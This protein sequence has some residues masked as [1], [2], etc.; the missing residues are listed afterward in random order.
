MIRLSFCLLFAAMLTPCMAQ[1]NDDFSDGDFTNNPAWSGDLTLFQVNAQLE[2][3]SAGNPATE[4]IYL[5]TPSTRVSDTEWRF[6]VR[7]LNNP[8]SSNNL[9]VYLVSDQADL[10]GPLNGYFIAA[11]GESGLDDSYDLYRQDGSSETLLIDGI[12]GLANPTDA[13]LQVLRDGTGN[14]SLAVDQGSTG[15][16]LSQGNANDATY[17]SST[18]MGVVVAHTSTRASDYFVDDVY[19]GD[20]VIDLDPPQL[21][22]AEAL[23]DSEVAVQFDEPLDQASATDITHYNLDQGV[24]QPA[25]AQLDGT[26]PTR[27]L[28]TLS[29]LL[30][31]QT[32]YELTV[33]DVADLSGNTIAPAQSVSFLYLVPDQPGLRDVIFNEFLP[34]PTPSQGLPEE[35]F[36]ELYNRSNKVIDLDGW[37][38][39]DSSGTVT[40][41]A[42]V[43][44]PGEYVL[45]V[46]SADVALFAPFGAVITPGSLPALNNGGD[47]MVLK[48]NDGTL[49]DSLTYTDDWYQDESRSDGGY[50]L[51]LINPENEACPAPANW[52]AAEANVGGTPG[53]QNSVFSLTPETDPPGI[54]SANVINASTI[55]LCFDEIMDPASLEIAAAFSL[56]Q[57]IGAAQSAEV[58][59][60]GQCVRL[61]FDGNLSPG[62][63]YSLSIGGVKD[64]S[65]N[66]IQ[67]GTRVSVAQGRPVQ[68]F[69]VVINEILADPT[70]VVGLPSVDFLELYNRSNE[71]L[72]ISRFR[73][74]DAAGS[75]Q[76][77]SAVLFPGEYLIV[78]DD[79][80]A[81]AFESFGRVIGVPGFPNFNNASDSLILRNEFD[82]VID[83]VFYDDDWYRDDD[84]SNG[85]FT[86]ERIDPNF[87]D[88]NQPLNWRASEAAIGG[89]PG[90]LN[91]VDGDYLDQ[92]P[93][94]LDRVIALNAQTLVAFFSEPMDPTTLETETNYLLDQGI[95]PPSLARVTSLGNQA[96]SLTLT[97]G[98]QPKTVYTLTANDLADC[99]GNTLSFTVEL[100]LAEDPQP[101][102]LVFNEIF[103]DPTPRIGLPEA[104]FIEL[105]NRTDKILSLGGLA[106]SDGGT[107]VVLEAGSIFPGQSIIL[108]DPENLE[109]FRPL[110]RVLGVN[111]PALGNSNDSL[112][113]R[114]SDGRILDYL[115]YRDTWYGSVEAA[116]G[117]RTLERIDPDFVDCNN[118]GNWRAS[119]ASSGG[120]PGQPN[121]I[122]GEFRDREPPRVLAIRPTNNGIQIEFDEQMDPGPLED[123]TRYQA[124]GGLGAPILALAEAPHFRRV[125]LVFALPL[126]TN[127][128]YTLQIDNLSDCVGNLLST[129]QPF[130]L[131]IPPQ[132]GELLINEILFNPYTGG[133]D[134][135]EVINASE[136]LLDLATLRIAE[137]VPGTDTVFNDFRLTEQSYV[138]LPGQLVC[139]TTDELF[140][141]LAYRPPLDAR[142][143]EVDRLPSYD[144]REGE[145]VIFTYENDSL[146]IDR[147]FYLDD[148]HYPTLKDDDGVSLERISLQVPTQEPDNWHSASSLVGYATP[149][150]ANSQ[151]QTP[152]QGD[153]EVSLGSQVFSPNL[154]GDNDVLAIN[155][156]FGFV[157][158]NARVYVYDTRGHLVRRLQENI[159][160]D[161]APGTFFW[162]G[163]GDRG[164][165]LPIGM[166]II[167]FEVTNNDTGERRAFRRVAVLA[168]Q[169]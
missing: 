163:F 54:L 22:R 8:S 80:A 4:T 114:L 23:S 169:L 15:I 157:G 118:L 103:P 10:T 55:A 7:Y 1:V 120:T 90:Q 147:F 2:L 137:G 159:L 53:G 84:R 155:Y 59:S 154:D 167:L 9:R 35:E 115:Y 92:Q 32:Q 136:N 38:F 122:R 86:L 89:T 117:G 140:Q 95:G 29:T 52:R 45:I 64:C 94:A 12:D 44:L 43:L 81:P 153:S 142:F 34:D 132:P 127:R 121:S 50:T 125:E 83:Y 108:C 96:L 165:K 74:A 82:E 110:G 139:L 135:V 63:V 13:T 93:P 133:A 58:D 85:G 67:N 104:E 14:W 30:V 151:A 106:L 66:L 150:Y 144:D 17:L 57:G 71:V 123:I 46:A 41:P 128:A 28:L 119:E 27:V 26:D 72:D 166:Y 152:A 77:S 18:H 87:V 62:T 51:E 36:I 124:D 109:A 97:P 130:G 102:E 42:H 88:C 33:Q 3:Q 79:D 65:G 116:Q 129:E 161:P 160:L 69:E 146:I 100:G 76:W 162:D 37:T 61:S 24:G 107:P 101:F 141:R 47:D 126:D 168:D 40:L 60:T 138:L 105:Y 131:A 145:C 164:Q 99:A 48:A 134:F 20:E 112:T 16:F 113:L 148:Y 31:N 143:L 91:A 73:I 158:A 25:S 11:G 21:L 75:A 5:S 68:P 78:C 98:L 149:G 49:I 156:Q 56:D 19:V 39:S 6:Q 70:P 111:L